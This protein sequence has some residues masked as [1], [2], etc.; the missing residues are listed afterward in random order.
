M[1]L[2]ESGIGWPLCVFRNHFGRLPPPPV[3]VTAVRSASSIRCCVP[4]FCDRRRPLRIQRRT[5]SGSRPTLRA[6]S[7]T[8]SIV[9]Y[10]YMLSKLSI[11]FGV[12]HFGAMDMPS[13]PAEYRFRPPEATEAPDVTRLGDKCDAA[14]GAPPSLTEDVIRHLWRRPR[15]DLATDAW[16]VEHGESI[17]GYAEVWGMDPT[18]LSGF[19]FVHPDHTRRG[20]GSALATVV[21]GRAAEKTSGTARLFSAVTTQDQVGARLLAARGY[22][23]A[24]RFRQMEIE[25]ERGLGAPTPPSGIELRRLDPES[26]LPVAHRVLQEAFEDHWDHSPTTFEEFLDR[27]VRQDDFDPTLWIIAFDAGE[28]VGVLYGAA[29]SDRG[30]VADLGVLRSHRGRGI[31]TALLQESFVEFERRGLPLVRL[32]VDSDSLTGA[33]ALYERVGMQVVSSYDLW[34]RAI[35]GS[36]ARSRPRSVHRST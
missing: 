34:V 17:V 6:A 24:R 9:V 23:W 14:V 28:P 36:D 31:A 10:Y 19:A 25:V 35:E 4:T 2:T 21:E 12:T 30:W 18:R 32:N 3:P 5:V 7:G 16:V 20:I 15:F 22:E 33:V 27:S 29:D 11:S 13:L 26:D 8:V 1:S